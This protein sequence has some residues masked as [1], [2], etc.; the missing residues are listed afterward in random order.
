MS[1]ELTLHSKEINSL[2]LS[3][4]T[5]TSEVSISV[6]TSRC[7]KVEVI[8]FYSG[9]KDEGKDDKNSAQEACSE[10]TSVEEKLLMLIIADEFEAESSE[11]LSK[12]YE[13]VVSSSGV[14]E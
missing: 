2:N 1:R 8:V 14:L 10:V 4:S 3:F 13:L 12:H 9:F 6:S 11:H 7:D 5:V